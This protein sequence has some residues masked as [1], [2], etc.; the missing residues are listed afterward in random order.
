MAKS[1]RATSV[2]RNKGLRLKKMQPLLADQDR[3]RQIR[4]TSYAAL[5][6]VRAAEAEGEEMGEVDEETQ[7]AA[8]HAKE[9]ERNDEQK[10]LLR[11]KGHFFFVHPSIKKD[12]VFPI[13]SNPDGKVAPYKANIPDSDKNVKFDKKAQRK[14]DKL[15]GKHARSKRGSGL[16]TNW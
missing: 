8:D 7:A 4:L 2:K 6:K 9:L 16:Q 14:L 5:Q 1:V 12:E 10:R 13:V 11:D 15:R 3:K